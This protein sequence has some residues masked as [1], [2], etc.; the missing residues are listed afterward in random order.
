[1]HLR[2][3]PTIEELFALPLPDRMNHDDC[4]VALE[5][6]RRMIARLLTGRDSDAIGDYLLHSFLSGHGIEVLE[7]DAKKGALRVSLEV[8][9]SAIS[10]RLMVL[11]NCE[12]N[13]SDICDAIGG[14]ITFVISR[15]PTREADRW[16]MH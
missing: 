12:P 11:L 5:S 3:N 4:R 7:F 9:N 14:Q 6:V 15:V 16:Y 13:V 8:L 1:M 2:S 10:E